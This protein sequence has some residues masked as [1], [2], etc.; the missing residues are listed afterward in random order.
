MQKQ[1]QKKLGQAVMLALAISAA[2]P[3]AAYGQEQP[4]KV[5]KD[6]GV[7]KITATQEALDEKIHLVGGK[8]N[9]DLNFNGKNENIIGAM[10]AAGAGSVLNING[11]ATTTIGK[12]NGKDDDLMYG[13]MDYPD[14]DHQPAHYEGDLKIKDL[15]LVTA[16]NGGVVNI[17][18]GSMNLDLLYARNGSDDANNPVSVINVNLT[19][20]LIGGDSKVVLGTY[21][22]DF[23]RQLGGVGYKYYTGDVIARRQAEINIKANNV[24]LNNVKSTTDAAITIV[25]QNDLDIKTLLVHHDATGKVTGKNVTIGSVGSVNGGVQIDIGDIRTQQVTIGAVGMIG[26]SSERFG[27]AAVANIFS[28]GNITLGGFCTAN[29]ATEASGNDGTINS[30][31]QSFNLNGDV[32]LENGL[33]NVNAEKIVFDSKK[34]SIS[35]NGAIKMQAREIGGSLGEIYFFDEAGKNK[36]GTMELQAGGKGDLNITKIEQNSGNYVTSITG[37]DKLTVAKNIDLD[38]ADYNDMKYKFSQKVTLGANELVIGHSSKMEGYSSVNSTCGSIVKLTGNR[39]LKLEGSFTNGGQAQLVADT[40]TAYQLGTEKSNIWGFAYA[41]KAGTTDVKANNMQVATSVYSTDGGVTKITAGNL[42][43]T[44]AGY[45]A[46]DD[47][48]STNNDAGF[49][50]ADKGGQVQ[51]AILNNGSFTGRT[52]DSGKVSDNF[53]VTDGK[54]DLELGAGAVWNVTGDSSLTTLKN[55]GLIDLTYKEAE[56]RAFTP[57]SLTVDTLEGSGA[58]KVNTDGTKAD[59]LKINKAGGSVT[60][61]LN[62]DAKGQWQQAKFNDVKVINVADADPDFKVDTALV[63]DGGQLY[64]YKAELV[65]QGNDYVLSGGYKKA[66]TQISTVNALA[67]IRHLGAAVQSWRSSNTGDMLFD[68]LHDL[69]LGAQEGLWG[70]VSRSKYETDAVNGHSTETIIGVDKA[71]AKG[72]TRRYTGAAVNYADS[73][74]SSIFAKGKNKNISLA[75]Y[76]SWQKDS[77]QYFD[78]IVKGTHL[79]S[80]YDTNGSTADHGKLS[81][82]G[83]NFSLEAGQN[84]QVAQSISIE[85][86]ARL[87]YGHLWAG[88]FTS[89]NGISN[90]MDGRDSLVGSLGL[91]YNKKLEGGNRLYAKAAMHHEFSGSGRLSMADSMGDT[92]TIDLGSK[93]TWYELG[94]GADFKLSPVCNVYAQVERVAGG[95]FDIPWRVQAGF[96][97][98]F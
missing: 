21:Q 34:I 14:K 81:G 20:D 11:N 37:V 44:G 68:R 54:I 36:E 19:G 98:T 72:S 97:Y 93:G 84:L 39:L 4:E 62:T 24:S 79:S 55:N 17:T 46:G 74:D 16:M 13:K 40:L 33:L 31:S 83:A 8:Q 38:N 94:L 91:R 66:G 9:V 95:D 22:E 12:E 89:S 71:A 92:A 51:L 23:L 1:K 61:V 49:I 88:S 60:L 96:N 70:S 29:G 32:K 3:L 64:H 85:P 52:M 41:D 80:E 65:K 69:R 75:A 45:D 58:V 5:E 77:G 57:T 10:G 73:S 50:W 6:Y 56:T 42:H 78:L 30:V 63:D 90:K 48:N 43:M 28:E 86:Y 82:W 27:D 25:A 87:T 26:S 15:A 47:T 53:T 67:P 76:G 7:I 2:Y 59:Q 18:G 35:K